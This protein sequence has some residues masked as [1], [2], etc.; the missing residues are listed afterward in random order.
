MA[1]L[2]LYMQSFAGKMQMRTGSVQSCIYNLYDFIWDFLKSIIQYQR[3]FTWDLLCDHLS[4]SGLK[5][6]PLEK[7]CVIYSFTSKRQSGS[8]FYMIFPAVQ[9]C[10]IFSAHEIS[11]VYQLYLYLCNV[12]IHVAPHDFLGFQVELS[13][14]LM[15][16]Y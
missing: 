3:E 8:C 15:K 6:Y 16:N 4:Q 5:L 12:Q 13:I 14:M 1:N 7:R 2:A 10:P 11:T 9:L